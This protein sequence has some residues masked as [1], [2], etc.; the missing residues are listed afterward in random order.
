MDIIW[1]QIDSSVCP[2]DTTSPSVGLDGLLDVQ[3]AIVGARLSCCGSQAHTSALA[4]ARKQIECHGVQRK[5]VVRPVA[6]CI[7][8]GVR[9]L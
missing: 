6:T 3:D 7:Q 8:S 9:R 1:R 4:V 5:E 2:R